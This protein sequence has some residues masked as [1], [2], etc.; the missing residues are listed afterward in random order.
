MV[1]VHCQG[2]C[3]K[4]KGATVIVTIL[5][6]I[7]GRVVRRQRGIAHDRK[8]Q[9]SI[10]VCPHIIGS[11][12][13]IEIAAL[14]SFILSQCEQSRAQL[15]SDMCMHKR[16]GRRREFDHVDVRVRACVRACV[17]VRAWVRADGEPAQ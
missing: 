12:V 5:D 2:P 14:P 6:A 3:L 4:F 9:P 17:F 1:L 15:K 8:V 11:F 16:N 13:V 10:C 7:D